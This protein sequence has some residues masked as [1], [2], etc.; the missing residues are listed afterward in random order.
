VAAMP[1]GSRGFTYNATSISKH[2]PSASGV[3][4]IFR[5]GLWIYIGET[6]D[7]RRSLL[8]H[9][10][11]ADRSITRYGPTGFSFELWPVGERKQ[12]CNDL[13][14]ELNPPCSHVFSDV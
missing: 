12:R 4:A 10:S 1:W 2:A 9:F 13:V 5:D 6:D 11:E 8:K 7:I 3:Y 14:W